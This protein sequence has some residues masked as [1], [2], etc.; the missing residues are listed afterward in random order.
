MGSRNLIFSS[1]KR[2]MTF[3][4]LKKFSIVKPGTGRCWIQIYVVLLSSMEQINQYLDSPIF[5]QTIN[6]ERD[7]T[8]KVRPT[9][10]PQNS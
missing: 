5:P 3:S 8:F 9:E 4:Q 1:Q 2:A 6:R 7:N 10:I